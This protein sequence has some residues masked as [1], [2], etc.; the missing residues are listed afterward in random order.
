MTDKVWQ[1]IFSDGKLHHV[2]TV[3]GRTYV[4]GAL[5]PDLDSP[6]DEAYRVQAHIQAHDE[7]FRLGD[8]K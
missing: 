4:D 7:W 1:E 2:V 6:P 5:R 8:E 3:D